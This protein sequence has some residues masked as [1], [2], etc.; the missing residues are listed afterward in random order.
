MARR[1]IVTPDQVNGGVHTVV[2][3]DTGM[4]TETLRRKATFSDAEVLKTAGHSRMMRLQPARGSRE[5][6]VN[7][8]WSR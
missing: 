7:S 1:V 6:T 2:H 4:G 5:G 8:K 3:D